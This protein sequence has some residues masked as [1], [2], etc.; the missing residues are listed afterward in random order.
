VTRKKI[1]A[2]V[3]ATNAP[4]PA[5]I[6]E[7]EPAVKDYGFFRR[8]ND[9]RLEFIS[10]CKPEA[11]LYVTMYSDDFERIMNEAFGTRRGKST[12]VAA[13]VEERKSFTE[14]HGASLP[15]RYM[16]VTRENTGTTFPLLA[17]P[18]EY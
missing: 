8:L 5:E 3:W 11:S 15:T 4:I 18:V 10:F 14:I 16:E 9:G 6:C 17:D 1:E 7:R 13:P 2:A 12:E